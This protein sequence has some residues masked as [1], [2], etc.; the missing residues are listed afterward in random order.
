L[1]DYRLARL[2]A[3]VRDPDPDH[4]FIRGRVAP[5]AHA[6]VMIK[7]AAIQLDQLQAMRLDHDTD[8][9]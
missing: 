2:E 7:H 3:D 4:G 1:S 8:R 9:A 5:E 6:P